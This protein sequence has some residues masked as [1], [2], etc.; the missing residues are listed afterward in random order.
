MGISTHILDTTRGRPAQGVSVTLESGERFV[1]ASIG[2]A[3]RDAPASP[4]H[5]R[6]GAVSKN[7]TSRRARRRCWT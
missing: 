5:P 1:T 6:P 3:T 4:E 2:V 7:Q